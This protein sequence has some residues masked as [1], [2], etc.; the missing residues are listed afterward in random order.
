MNIAWILLVTL[1]GIAKGPETKP[2]YTLFTAEGKATTFEK[3]SAA[4]AKQDVVF[5]G[6][7]HNDPIG[8]WLQ[9]ELATD[10][11]KR[12]KSLEIGMEMFERDDQL[13]LNEYLSG[14]IRE[15]SFKKEAKLWDNYQT[16]YRPII[17]FCQTHKL[18][19]WAT[20]VPRRY[21]N[22]VF[23]KGLEALSELSPEALTYIAPLPLTVDP[24]LPG[25]QQI[26]KEMGG[27]GS[28]SSA[29]L[30]QS[31][32]LKDA[33][34]AH[35][36]HARRSESSLLLHLNGA[37]HTQ[38]K[39]GIIWYLQRLAPDLKIGTI[40]VVQQDQL[41]TLDAAHRELADYIVVVP[42]NMTGTY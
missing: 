32:A 8:H 5:F 37:F 2:A 3:M 35:T 4:L 42:S 10:L 22:M 18:P 25:Y 40:Q 19:V 7:Q 15:T 17:A 30:V 34:M 41:E 31:Q 21:A 9:L 1:L 11:H 39:E 14:L 29:Y 24:E 26:A 12:V 27:H 36:I 28:H 23:Y 6:E 16:D 13:V 20:N 33:T 38:R